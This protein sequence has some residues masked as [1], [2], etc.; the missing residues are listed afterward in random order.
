MATLENKVALVTGGGR[1]I[2]AGIAECFLEAGA[3]VVTAQRNAP[4]GALAER[5]HFVETEL[6]RTDS[7]ERLVTGVISAH[8]GV[9]VLVNNAGVM[10]ERPVTEMSES[11]WDQL[12]SV[13]LKAPFLLTKQVVPVMVERGGGAIINIGSIEGLG[14]NPGHTAYC[15]SKGGIHA[16]TKAL[17]VELGGYGIRVNCIAPAGSRPTW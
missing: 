10:F 8:G 13:N 12:L 14:A 5:A 2:G 16:M 17:A 4:R 6:T 3:T 11:E 15:A 9:D 7:I 1:G